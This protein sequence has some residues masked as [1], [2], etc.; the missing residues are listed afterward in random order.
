[1][2]KSDMSRRRENERRYLVVNGMEERE[3]QRGRV[4]YFEVRL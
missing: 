2:R 1:V 4:D 3:K